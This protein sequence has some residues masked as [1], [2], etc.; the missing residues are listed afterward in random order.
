M[1]SFPPDHI[2]PDGR[3][4]HAQPKIARH[5]SAKAASGEIWRLRPKTVKDVQMPVWAVFR[6]VSIQIGSTDNV[7]L[8]CRA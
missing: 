6:H 8:A 5:G 3:L 4:G 1:K 7:L 2:V